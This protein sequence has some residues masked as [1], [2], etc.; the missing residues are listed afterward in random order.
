M[1]SRILLG[2]CV[3]TRPSGDAELIAFNVEESGPGLPALFVI[4]EAARSQGEQPRHLAIALA[5]AEIHVEAVL[6][7]LR[8]GNA[9]ER[10]CEPASVGQGDGCRV[11]VCTGI[12]LL[13]EGA[14]PEL[15]EGSCVVAV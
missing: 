12:D 5:G 6:G 13:S 7:D 9:A 14:R 4:G 15:C 8:L 11:V 1:P 2:G 3:V 10:Q